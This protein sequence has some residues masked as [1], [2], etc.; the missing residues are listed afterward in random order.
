MNKLSTIFRYLLG[1]MFLGA[2]IAGIL[3]K[4]PPPESEA[5]QAFMMILASSG[6]IYLVKIIEIISSIAL[7]SGFFVP[8]ALFLLAPITCIIL[9]FHFAL[10]MSG[11]PVGI[12]L[13]TLWILTAYSYRDI[14]L[15][16]LQAKPLK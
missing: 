10:D 12:I 1:I 3:G 7:L 14:F 13:T 9:W 11:A 5:A 4:I 15:L 8:A 2:S 6:L 16:F